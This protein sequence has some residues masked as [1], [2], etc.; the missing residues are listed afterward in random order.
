MANPPSPPTP[1]PAKTPARR[2]AGAVLFL[3][4]VERTLRALVL[5]PGDEA[6]AHLARTYARAIDDSRRHRDPERYARALER[7]GPKLLGVLD[8]LGATP[9]GRG[10]LLGGTG[11]APPPEPEDDEEERPPSPVGWLADMRQARA[12]RESSGG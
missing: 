1:K 6:A 5:G 12:S 10:R 2:S 8:K 11:A 3:P 9:S 4:V 7:M